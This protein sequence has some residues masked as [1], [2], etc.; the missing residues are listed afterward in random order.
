[1]VRPHLEPN[2][3][4]ACRHYLG[5]DQTHTSDVFAYVMPKLTPGLCVAHV[6]HRKL[7][8]VMAVWGWGEAASAKHQV[9]FGLGRERVAE[10]RGTGTPAETN[11]AVSKPA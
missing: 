4:L 3:G 9:S 11:A 6:P 10:L 8:L 2:T 1:M 7:L 5:E